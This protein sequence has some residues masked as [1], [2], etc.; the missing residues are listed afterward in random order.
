MQFNIHNIDIFLKE[1]WRDF[2][3][4]PENTGLIEPPGLIE[5]RRR[6][7][8]EEKKEGKKEKKEVFTNQKQKL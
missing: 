3:A 8:R 2:R 1:M 7:G 5:P 4:L 6:E